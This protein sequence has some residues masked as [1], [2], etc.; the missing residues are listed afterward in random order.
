[1]SSH[2]VDDDQLRGLPIDS[3]AF[4]RHYEYGYN[5]FSLRVMLLHCLTY[6]FSV[7]DH[8]KANDDREGK[9]PLQLDQL[10]NI[11]PEDGSTRIAQELLELLDQ[12]V[13]ENPGQR[14]NNRTIFFILLRQLKGILAYSI[15][16]YFLELVFKLGFSI[17]LG[18]L[19]S[20]VAKGETGTAYVFA[21]ASSAVWFL[22]QIFRHNAY[23]S[24]PIISCRVRAGLIL[25]MYAKVSRLTSFTAKSA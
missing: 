4:E 16:L 21:G 10:I 17:L 20:A 9:P 19:F 3:T 13:A 18:Y 6:L 24:I 15:T 5:W 7:K 22:G 2:R 8:I 12:W 1:M 14:M 25:L 11:Q 23:Y